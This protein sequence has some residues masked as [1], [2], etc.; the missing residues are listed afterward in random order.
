MADERHTLHAQDGK[1]VD[2]SGNEV[3]FT[4]VSW[5]G[6]ETDCF[7][8]Q[9]LDRRVWS[10]M[11]DQMVGLG[12]NTLRLP[13][14]NELFNPASQPKG[15]DKNPDLVG[16]TGPQIMDKIGKGRPAAA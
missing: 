15:I 14:S 13:F 1:I 7:A 2:A 12:F 3:V 10:Q 8:P 5:F 11:L 6:L 9:G 4:G 16:L